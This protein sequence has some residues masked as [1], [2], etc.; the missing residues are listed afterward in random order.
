MADDEQPG[1]LVACFGTQ[2][3]VHGHVWDNVP[4]DSAAEAV[5]KCVEEWDPESVTYGMEFFCVP[6]KDAHIVRAEWRFRAGD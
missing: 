6:M 4:A 2:V 1:W 5:E 3:G